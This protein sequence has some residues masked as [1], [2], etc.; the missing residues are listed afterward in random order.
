M[1]QMTSI[2]LLSDSLPGQRKEERT[3]QASDRDKTSGRMSEGEAKTKDAQNEEWNS[4]RVSITHSNWVSCAA[5]NELVCTI[6]PFSSRE[7]NAF[8]KQHRLAVGPRARLPVR[9]RR[10]RRRH[11]AVLYALCY[12]VVFCRYYI[13]TNRMRCARICRERD[14]GIERDDIRMKNRPHNLCC[15]S[16]LHFFLFWVNVVITYSFRWMR[17]LRVLI[18]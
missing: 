4:K 11:S 15:F 9:S 16:L 5:R 14:E 17:V 7:E 12:M 2:E 18:Q 1:V 13:C 8:Y 3:Q 6:H 10:R